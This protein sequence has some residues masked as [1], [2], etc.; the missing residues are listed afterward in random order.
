M[1]GRADWEWVWVLAGLP[2]EDVQ[3]RVDYMGLEFGR[4]IGTRDKDL[5]VI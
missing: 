3:K 4:I 1:I 2:G 5:K